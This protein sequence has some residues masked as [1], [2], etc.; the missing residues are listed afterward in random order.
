MFS[1]HQLTKY[2]TYAR[3]YIEPLLSKQAGEQIV[4]DYLSMRALGVSRKTISATPRQL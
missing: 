4:R 2:I 3:E 1:I